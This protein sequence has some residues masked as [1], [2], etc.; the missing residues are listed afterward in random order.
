MRDD[1]ATVS[2]GRI[3]RSTS[4]D[5][6]QVTATVHGQGPSLVFLPAGPADAGTAWG[7]VLPHL[8]ERFSCHMLNTRGRGLSGDDLDHS[9]DR[10]IDDISAYAESVGE[11]LGLVEWG[12]FIGGAWSLF[13]AH[14]SSAI[15][16][17][18]AFDPLVLGVASDEDAA[19][20]EGILERVSDLV[21]KG[22]LQEAARR[23]VAEMAEHGFYTEADMA[24]GATSELWSASIGSIPLFFEEMD[25][26]GREGAPDPAD[27]SRLDAVSVPVLL[28]HGTR[29]HPMNREL[30]RFVA[31]HLPQREVRAIPGA[32]HYGPMT[33]PEPVA[34]EL[35][36]FF[37]GARLAGRAG[38]GS[39]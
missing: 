4:S 22:H 35:V 1:L 26:A 38:R 34:R 19:L 6:T 32:G 17:V 3:H 37:Q 30:V 8:T 20:L 27:P 29:S 25:Q 12:S 28:L 11:P 23:F 24:G 15:H 5:G 9:P 2:E 7:R 21:T 31:N 13:A 16:A 36:E 39:A 33:H 14:R 10:L 18:A